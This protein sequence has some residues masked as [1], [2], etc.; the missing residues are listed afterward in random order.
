MNLTSKRKVK[1]S[2]TNILMNI[3]AASFVLTPVAFGLDAD[4]PDNPPLLTTVDWTKLEYYTDFDDGFDGESEMVIAIKIN[5]GGSHG[6]SHC[7]WQG[8]IDMDGDGP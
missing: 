4:P 3:C 2:T 5:W 7:G 6:I 8:S 1:Y